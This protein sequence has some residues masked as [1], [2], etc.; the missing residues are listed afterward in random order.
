MKIT[1]DNFV[2]LIVTD[3]AEEIWDKEVFDLYILYDDD[4]ESLVENY[5]QLILAINEGFDIGIEVGH[6]K[7]VK[8]ERTNNL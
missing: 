3:N 7:L 4:S 5:K 2:W 6:L 1:K 8:D